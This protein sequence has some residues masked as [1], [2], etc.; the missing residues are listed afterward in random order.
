MATLFG[1]TMTR[2]YILERVGDISQIGGI[3]VVDLA[4]GRERGVR[5]AQFRT[6]SGLDFTVL[7]DRGMDIDRADYKGV[8]LCWRS[9]TQSAHPAYFEP[10]GL[11]WLRSFFGGLLTTCGLTY[12]GHPTT[13]EG[14]QL[15]LHGH[16]SNIPARSVQVEERWEGD[17][18]VMAV[19][20]EVTEAAVFG[21]H[22][23]LR[24][25]VSARLGERRLFVSDTV[26]NRGHRPE[27]LMVLYHI[28]FG[29]PIVDS[30]A[31]LVA[32]VE[33]VTPMDERAE[34]EPEGYAH[35]LT[36]QA[37]YEERCYRFTFHPDDTGYVHVGLVNPEA[38]GGRGLGAYLRFRKDQLPY[39]VEWKMMGQGEYVVA[40]EPANCPLAP[41]DRLRAQGELVMLPPGAAQE[42][43]IEIGVLDGAEEIER[44]TRSVTGT[45]P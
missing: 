1:K 26:E 11:Q 37:D 43:E 21:P 22:M 39:L 18:F 33:T 14:E 20:G 7:I 9:A 3:R 28:N 29:Y 36:P 5:A 13:D 25:R 40:I 45:T 15:G 19:T 2:N 35:F 44:F 32:T 6:A 30:P 24:R 10:E 41:R 17:D 38:D 23:V 16:I 12:A 4:D 34:R 31:R 8:P 42:F 27:P